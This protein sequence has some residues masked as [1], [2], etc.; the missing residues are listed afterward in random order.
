MMAKMFYTIDET[1]QALGKTEEEVKQLTRE[2]KLREFRDGPRLMF[3]ADQV[4]N[5][6]AELGIS[7]DQIDLGPSDTGSALSLSDSRSGTGSGSVLS[8][9]DTGNKDDTAMDVGLS[10]TRGPSARKGNTKSGTSVGSGTG[11]NVLGIDDSDPS[12]KT[13]AGQ[14]SYAD[15]ASLDQVGSGSG[16]LDLSRENRDD[17][18]LGGVLEEIS[19]RGGDLSASGVA[20]GGSASAP[21]MAAVAEP[22]RP[23]TAAMA[24]GGAIYVEAPD[25]VGSGLGGAALGAAIFSTLGLMGIAG[26][27]SGQVPTLLESFK[28]MQ[29]MMFAG[30]GAGLAAI[31]FVVGLV[32]GKR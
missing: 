2:G 14:S 17:T 1:T 28:G 8:L 30:I 12:A 3:K 20:V 22:M 25:P 24:R 18:S 9:A 21:A 16:L 23:N 7:G 11:I 31:L 5:L 4:E 13:S 15:Q 27:V 32:L 29:P 26:A 10:G 6:K 19:P